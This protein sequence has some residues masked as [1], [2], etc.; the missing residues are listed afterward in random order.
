MLNNFVSSITDTLNDCP[1]PE[2]LVV[3]VTVYIPAD[4]LLSN[5]FTIVSIDLIVLVAVLLTSAFC[6]STVASCPA[7]ILV[8][9]LIAISL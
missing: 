1:V 9:L 8:L 3:P 5:E 4:L 2:P 7:F 6:P